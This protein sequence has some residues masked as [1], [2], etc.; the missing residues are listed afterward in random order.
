MLKLLIDACIKCRCDGFYPQLLFI[1]YFIL[2]NILINILILE[3]Y[4]LRDF[5]CTSPGLAEF[6]SSCQKNAV[7][8]QMQCSCASIRKSSAGVSVKIPPSF[9]LPR[10]L[11]LSLPPLALFIHPSFLS[12]SHAPLPFLLRQ[13]VFKP[14][15]CHLIYSSLTC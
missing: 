2:F 1:A 5:I 13:V 4:Y 14:L 6:S 15:H 7:Q 11:F 9:S 12:L 8:R 10:N 3:K